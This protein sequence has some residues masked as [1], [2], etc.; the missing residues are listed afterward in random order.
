MQVPD[1]VINEQ[2]VAAKDLSSTGVSSVE[3]TAPATVRQGRMP[4]VKPR[5]EDDMAE[6]TRP[7]ARRRTGAGDRGTL[8]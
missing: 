5:E 2:V 3:R 1:E 8:R 4:H 6:S 7:L